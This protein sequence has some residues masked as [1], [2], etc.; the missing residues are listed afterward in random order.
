[1]TSL[2]I[3]AHLLTFQQY[4]IVATC[5][6]IPV[7]ACFGENQQTPDQ[8]QMNAI[9][10]GPIAARQVLMQYNIHESLI[11]LFDEIRPARSSSGAS[12]QSVSDAL[13]SRGIQT[14]A[15]H[16]GPSVRIDWQFPVIVHLN[17]RD[18]SSGHFVVQ[19]PSD[20]EGKVCEITSQGQV[21]TLDWRTA[22]YR[23]SG[24]I[25]L[26]APEASGSI[27]F[28]T[29]LVPVPH[30]GWLSIIS[31]ATAMLVA[32]TLACGIAFNTFTVRNKS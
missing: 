13:V 12:L 5:I 18:G 24:A 23:R 27:D 29:A 16:V 14:K 19:L 7:Q 1:M 4:V 32:S 31:A 30:F 26:T 15:V 22:A 2:P 28:R 17:G 3:L 25:L 21:E 11:T 10:C 6:L 8:V 9:M 20:Q